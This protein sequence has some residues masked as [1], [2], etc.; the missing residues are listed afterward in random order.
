VQT[1]RHHLHRFSSAFETNIGSVTAKLIDDWLQ[2]EK[3]LS[4]RARNNFRMSIVTL[5]HFARSRGYLPKNEPIEAEAVP[6]AKDRDSA[7]IGF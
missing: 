7:A 5:F 1:L 6:K 3:T 4:S 2:S